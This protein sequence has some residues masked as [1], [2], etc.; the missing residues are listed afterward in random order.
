M[1]VAHNLVDHP[2]VVAKGNRHRGRLGV[3]KIDAKVK[4]VVGV[5]HRESGVKKG[6]GER[7][8]GE[9]EANINHARTTTNAE[10]M[11]RKN[12]EGN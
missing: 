8:Q 9:R 3:R 6:K 2:R 5:L 10:G 12:D 4:P 1:E 7:W 11:E